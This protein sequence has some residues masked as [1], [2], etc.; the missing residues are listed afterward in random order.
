MKCCTLCNKNSI[1]SGSW[2]AHCTKEYLKKYREKHKEHLKK[3]N[4]DW[5]QSNKEAQR[6]KQY[7]YFKTQKSRIQNMIKSARKRSKEKNI[8]FDLDIKWLSSLFKEQN[9]KCI[10]TNIDFIIPTERKNHLSTPFTPSLD[11]IDP[12]KGY[13]KNNTRLVCYAMNCCLHDFGENIFEKIA[14]IYLYK[15]IKY[16][17]KIENTHTVSTPK[18]IKDKKYSESLKGIITGLYNRSKNSKQTKNMSFN[19]TKE[20]LHELF[21]KQNNKCKITNITFDYTKYNNKKASPFK[22]SIDRIDSSKGYTQDNVRLVCVIINFALN[23]FGEEIFR[24]ICES[25][26]KNIDLLKLSGISSPV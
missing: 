1:S 22:P 6:E 26:I 12:T 15:D 18:Q 17:P 20:F 16:L 11:R 21:Q 2:C 19:L 10:L 9:N 13:T 7:I 5:R 3:L 14:K 8:D 23:E 25:Y 4:H 24:Q